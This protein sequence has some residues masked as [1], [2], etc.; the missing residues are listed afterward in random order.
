MPRPEQGRRDDAVNW[1]ASTGRT[2]EGNLGSGGADVPPLLADRRRL[3]TFLRTSAR[4]ESK[5]IRALLSLKQAAIEIELPTFSEFR[6]ALVADERE[7]VSEILTAASE[8]ERA[9]LAAR[10]ITILVEE[11]SRGHVDEARS[12][13]DVVCSSEAFAGDQEVRRE[14]IEKAADEPDLQR[15]LPNLDPIAVHERGGV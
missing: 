5:R 7:R 4:I 12:V 8:D 1:T 11:L 2:G 15:E 14:V 13:V 6:D 3:A 9:K 10:V